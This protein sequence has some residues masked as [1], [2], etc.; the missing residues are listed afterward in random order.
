MT[1]TELTLP[2][3][4]PAQPDE[5]IA[6]PM[7]W[8]PLLVVLAGVFMTTL[9]FFIVN[10]A[11]PSLQTDLHAGGA[12]V[13]FV[14]AGFGLAFAA[15]MISAGRFGDLWGRR[16]VFSIGMALFT[17][18]SALCGIAPSPATLIGARVVQ[19]VAAALILPQVL[20]I[21]STVYDGQRRV[22]AFSAYGL[23]L[24]CAGVFGQLIGGGLIRLDV[25]GLGWRTIFLLN[26]P[27]G[28]AALAM[29][30]RV[31][32]ESR[33]PI[34]ARLDP[35]GA[36][37]I[38]ATLVA[39]VLPLVEGRAQGWPI[40]TYA[41]LAGSAVLAAGTLLHQRGLHRN[42]GAPT[43][44]LGLFRDR[45]FVVGVLAGLA[46]AL[47]TASF[48]LVLA[49]YLQQGQG[50]TPLASGV[51]FVP[52]GIGYF[53]VS[54]QSGRVAGRIGAQVIA[55][56]GAVTAAGFLLL[57]ETASHLGDASVLWLLPGLV[58]AGAGLG[59]VMAPLPT[60]TLQSVPADDAA[61]AS[62]VLSTAQQVGGALGVAV[63][64]IVYFGTDAESVSVAFSHSL[65]LLAAFPIL[66]AVVIQF[67]CRQS[68]R[69]P[70]TTVT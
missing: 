41:C 68:A 43:L 22:R 36:V 23:T 16:R 17:L 56:G 33:S 54:A 37:L 6:E 63:V 60:V 25:F 29:V 35:T 27:V 13:Q 18:A 49:L 65:A 24:G 64:G 67:L 47:A 15:G 21:L 45:A 48:F 59:L 58:A 1:T 34:A 62:G 32:P 3:A 46:Y 70:R 55:L 69:A 40:W 4:I 28:V 38:T 20:A 57:G 50:L 26:V 31:L 51:I 2:T 7:Q 11:I 61:A 12:A 30:G 19:G 53:I 66:A 8:A 5:P 39:L 42:G 52:L 10:V 14:V 44:A 9:D